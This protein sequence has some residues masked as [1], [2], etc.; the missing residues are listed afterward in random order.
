[1][2][3]AIHGAVPVRDHVAGT[4]FASTHE[5]V[6]V[7]E[8]AGIFLGVILFV[9]SG[10]LLFIRMRTGDVRNRFK[11]WQSAAVGQTLSALICFI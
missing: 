11:L 4:E 1:M 10:Y 2:R 9:E 5:C 7:A 6:A 3:A 8:A